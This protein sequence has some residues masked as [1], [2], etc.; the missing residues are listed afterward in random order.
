MKTRAAHPLPDFNRI[1]AEGLK[2]VGMET[3]SG[4]KGF[5]SIEFA[6]NRYD[7]YLMLYDDHLAMNVMRPREKPYMEIERLILM[8]RSKPYALRLYFKQDH[9]TFSMTILDRELLMAVYEFI[10]GKRKEPAG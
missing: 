9:R 6:R 5:G 3:I 10:Q 4:I 8:P 1:P 2:I 7:P